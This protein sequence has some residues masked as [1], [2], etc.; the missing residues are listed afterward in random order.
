[1]KTRLLATLAFLAFAL[2]MNAQKSFWSLPADQPEISKTSSW[3]QLSNYQV[4]QIDHKSFRDYLL[5][6]VP[7]ENKANHGFP[8][9]FPM[10]DGTQRT[11]YLSESPVMEPEL[12]AKYPE[13]KTYKG[14]D[15]INYMRMSISPYSFQVFILTQE[16]DIVIEAIHKSNLNLYG[17]FN[18]KDLVIQDPLKLSC[19]TKELAKLSATEEP[20]LNQK[21]QSRSNLGAGLPV[22]LRTYRLALACTGDWGQQANLGGGTL[23]TALDKMVASLSLINAVYEKDVSVH[24]NLIANNDRLIFLDPVIDPYPTPTSGGSTLGINTDVITAKV[25]R[26]TYDIG[27]VYTITC[28]DVGGIAFLGSVCGGIKGGGVTCW[29]TSDIA[30]VS[31][32]IT[33]HEMGHQFDASH[34]FSN[35]NG[36]ESA[37]SYEPGSGTS[38]MSYSGLCGGGLNVESGNLPHPNYFHVN[39]VERIINFTRKFDGSTCGISTPT[40]NTFPNPEILFPSG[41]Y[42][43]IRTPFKLSGK[44]TDMENDS[45]T[46]NWEQYDAGGYGPVLGEPSLTEEGPL[47]KSLF[48]GIN[49]IRIVPAWLT[50]LT[51]ANFERTEVLP[52]INR[53]INF[54]FTARDN[55][56]GSGGTAWKQTFF[57]AIQSAGP[58]SVTYPNDS[59]TDTLF[60]NVCNK[61]SWDVANTDKSLVN[62][63]R[64][65]IYLMPN[66]LITNNL[67]PLVL[68]TENDGEELITVPDT[69]VGASRARI[70][71][72]SAENIFFDVSDADIKVRASTSPKL[73]FGVSPNK[74]KFC[75]PNS[76]DIDITACAT[77]GFGGN[78]RLYVESGLP[79]K[80][81]Y[82]FEN[83]TIGVDGS[84]KLHLDFSEVR[85]PGISN[86]VVVAIS[87]NGDTLREEIELDLVSIDYSDLKTVF[88][89]SGLAGLSQ[90]IEFKWTLS[91]NAVTYELEVA[92]SPAFG[93]TIIYSIKGITG[94][95]FKPNILF[96]ENQLY[97][98]RIIPVNRCGAGSPTVPSPFHTINKSCVT[99]EYPGNVLSR[100]ANQT[101][102]MIVP[103]KDAGIISDVNLKSFKGSAI[104]VNS[105]S[106]TL[107]SPLGTRA[108]LFDKNC[109][110]TDQFDCSFDDDGSFTVTNGCP[111]IQGK[112]IRPI[113]SLTKF[114]S[115]N[116]KGD[117][118]LEISTDNRLSGFAEFNTYS[119]D[120]CSEILVNN[121]FLINNVGLQL[122]PS[123]TK[124][125]GQD[126]L[127]SQDND[128]TAAELIYTIVLTP[129]RGDLLIKGVVATDG[130][131]FTQKDIN[132]GNLSYRHQGAAMELDG[133][134][135]TVK[136]GTGGWFGSEFFRIQIGTVSTDDKEK[137][138]E[139]NVYPNPSKGLLQIAAAKILDKNAS[140]RIL[141]LQ[142]KVLLRKNI[143]LLKA[144]QVNIEEFSDGIYI[145]EIRSGRHFSATKLVLK[146]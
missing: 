130:S 90:A 29:Y 75:V 127:L 104:G 16:G 76:T 17:V 67:I 77:A 103:I 22:D 6:N 1:M 72:E 111:P 51:K 62:C 48:P 21:M 65:N 2:N 96:N 53:Q 142:G 97:Y 85:N 30:Y 70:L 128:N 94:S 11:F 141:N 115:E 116:K 135:F 136:D 58:F 89:A 138:L 84:T 33:C 12:A 100:R 99:T 50:I 78:V 15:G 140:L 95:S 24:L 145:L 7:F 64:V 74:L 43:P 125:I 133:F 14:T 134:L 44:A 124:S 52:T 9:Q 20:D 18:A 98:W 63:Q 110:V 36:N 88:P 122:N 102:N 143:G 146:R 10:P 69:L 117:W 42:I 47:F 120:I 131:S 92:T 8:V 49:P 19:G 38:I 112:I 39:S 45:L 31:Q 81:L 119:L 46:Y 118:R 139:I 4:F 126:L 73:N 35:C 34:T 3:N 57:R 60:T 144:E 107:V 26:G 106:L 32:R 79:D 113:E 109:G 23:A 13:I 87:P 137:E 61:V 68:N 80:G 71:V 27:H 91:Q 25:G 55:H 83:N 56:A 121:P 59:Q 66:R 101:G 37:T 105:V 5:N 123:E 54:R 86:L 132:D 108:I 93:N 129:Q 114:N 28:S 82:R 40:T 41:L